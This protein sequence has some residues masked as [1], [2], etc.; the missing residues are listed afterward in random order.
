MLCIPTSCKKKGGTLR[1][2]N[3]EIIKP[4]CFLCCWNQATIF[5][6]SFSNLS[7]FSSFFGPANRL[8]FSVQ[9]T[10]QN[11]LSVVASSSFVN[12]ISISNNG[13][14]FSDDLRYRKRM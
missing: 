1:H 13:D 6:S 8:I 5:S 11:E 10:T 7:K 3:V 2:L 9:K 14:F 12:P 4:V